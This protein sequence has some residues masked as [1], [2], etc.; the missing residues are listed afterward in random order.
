M[1]KKY[2]MILDDSGGGKYVN[3]VMIGTATEGDIR[4]EWAGAR[5]GMT[6]PTNWSMVNVV[7]FLNPYMPKRFSVADAQN[8][9]V[10]Q[11]IEKKFE[12]L[13]FIEDDTIPPVDAIVRFN[14]YIRDESH[15]VVS[16]LYY[17]RSIPSEPMIFRG[18]GTS[19]YTKW[20]MGDKVYCDGVP[21]GMLLI[22]VKILELMYKDAPE[23]M[24]YGGRTARRIFRNPD[25]QWMNEE[26]G[27]FGQLSGTTDLQWCEDVMKGGYFKKAGWDKFQKMKF[28]FLCDT[29]IFC[30]HIDRDG[31][32]YPTEF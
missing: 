11:A 31:T 25:D 8:L 18:R 15:P 17:T 10:Q 1:S 5:Y 12:W 30:R 13:W 21:T 20:K 32:M 29:N 3:R 16:G 14:K 23:Y 6:I 22:D 2:K 24:T 9:I 27:E 28:P 4:M 19:Y 26:T 7:Q